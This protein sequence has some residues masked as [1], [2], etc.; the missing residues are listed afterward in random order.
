M[1]FS[2]K[3]VGDFLGKSFTN[4][5]QCTQNHTSH[6]LSRA[7]E[8]I[9]QTPSFY[10]KSEHVLMRANDALTS[11]ERD[12]RKGWWTRL[13]QDAKVIPDAIIISQPVGQN[14]MTRE[15]NLVLGSTL[16]VALVFL[17]V[18]AVFGSAIMDV[19]VDDDQQS[20]FRVPVWERYT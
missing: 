7:F 15:F 19:I 14:R 9:A 11:N 3:V 18:S 1:V 17:F 16:A 8:D 20:D 6:R 4:A 13:S 2:T 10:V 5:G 12:T